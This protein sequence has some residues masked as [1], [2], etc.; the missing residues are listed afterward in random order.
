MRKDLVFHRGNGCMWVCR[1][2]SCCLCWLHSSVYLSSWFRQ[3]YFK[4]KQRCNASKTFFKKENAGNLKPWGCP[5]GWTCPKHLPSL[6][7][8]ILSWAG[9]SSDPEWDIHTFHIQGPTDLH[10]SMRSSTNQPAE[11]PEP[12]LPSITQ[13]AG[14]SDKVRKSLP[15]RVQPSPGMSLTHGC[16]RNPSSH[17][18]ATGITWPLR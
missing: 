3:L 7:N 11:I 13:L 9:N 12:L 2:S 1:H 18:H 8:Q 10:P 5:P 4:F 14:K 15:G 6:T 17:S 16:Q